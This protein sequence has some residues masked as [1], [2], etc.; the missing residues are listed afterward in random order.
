MNR[1]LSIWFLAVAW[2][3]FP[4]GFA[5][6]I[7]LP[8]DDQLIAKSPVILTGDVLDS[9]AVE[10]DGRIYTVTRVA[11]EQRLKGTAPSVVAIRE[12][13]G[14]VGDRFNVVFGSPTYTAGERIL[15]FLWPTEQGDYQT[16]DL[17]VGKFTERFTVDGDPL[18]FRD[19]QLAG[20]HLL[21]GNFEPLPDRNIQRQAHR[22]AQYIA[23]SAAGI[24]A[25]RD[26]EVEN[27]ELARQPEVRAN[28]TTIAEPAIYRWFAFDGGGSAS[29]VSIGTQPGFSG[30]GINEIGTAMS[31][32]NNAT[33][34]R[35]RYMYSGESSASPGGLSSPNG[36]NE[37]LLND[38]LREIDGS[39]SSSTGG[40]IGRGGFNN[41][42]NGGSW[43]SG[44]D[45]D[46]SHPLRT[47]SNVGNIIEGNLVIQ[48]GVT[49]SAGFTSNLLAAVLA[50]EFGH[51]LGLGHSA[52]VSA[53][54]YASLQSGRGPGLASD[55]LNAA[56]W[57]YPGTSGGST[58]SP[59]PQPPST[60]PAAPSNLGVS[61]INGNQL[62]M[63]WT[64]NAT[65]ASA[66]RVYVAPGA[67]TTFTMVGEI[68]A[69]RN[70]AILSGLSAGVS[71]RVRITARNS[72][73]ESAPSNTAQ[74]TIP[75]T[76]N[77]TLLSLGANRFRLTLEA[78]DHRTG[79]TGVGVAIPQN[80]L[81]GYFSIPDLTGN[82]SNPEVFV[83][84]LNGNT[85]NGKFW[86]FWGGLT[87][88]EYTVRVTDLATGT[89]QAYFKGGGSSCGGYDTNAFLASLESPLQFALSGSLTNV[90]IEEVLDLQADA[91]SS[92]GANLCVNG[93][94]FRITLSAR[95][96]RT[97]ATAPGQALPQNDLFGYFSIPGLTGNAANPEVFVK[98]LDGRAANGRF[99]LFY[100]GLTDLEYTV[101]VTDT[102]TGAMKG[103]TKPGGSAC[104]GFDSSAF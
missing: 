24:P 83:K 3:A 18:W 35:I 2:I 46:A 59:D 8:T 37:V 89:T 49:P 55:D 65:N 72:A 52:D 44:F 38:P 88:L 36:R 85:V 22:F 13:G 99:W 56:R 79:R 1:L 54:M 20:T 42:Q 80:D 64:I 19:V 91:C 57:L 12:V 102:L 9:A 31:S 32:W 43:T 92:S 4:V 77:P 61:I 48:D 71:Y 104:G 84:M 51:T 94:R 76:T 39:F 82:P 87:D 103:Y 33:G 16:R 10:Q 98:M 73:G 29:W 25:V 66:Q 97:G 81:F 45:A 93:G 41:V 96:P 86:V 34:A 5:T 70:S 15:V 27:P 53:L 63:N 78:R 68:S 21:D 40:V 28:F 60:V 69:T 14:Q 75:G 58:P 30:G 50:H 7:V 67:E 62:M 47:Y 26:Y 100:G 90:R 6:T 95:D 101:T 23:R 74:A 17:F 11:V